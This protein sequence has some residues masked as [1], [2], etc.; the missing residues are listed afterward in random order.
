MTDQM[1]KLAGAIVDLE[2]IKMA[3]SSMSWKKMLETPMVRPPPS[4]GHVSSPWYERALKAA[5]RDPFLAGD[6][7][8]SIPMQDHQWTDAHK[9]KVKQMEADSV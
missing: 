5:F 9:R 4:E 2:L 3:D 8:F 6:M 7:R 1:T